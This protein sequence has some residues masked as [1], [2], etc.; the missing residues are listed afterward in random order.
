MEESIEEIGRIERFW[1]EHPMVAAAL[2]ALI[3]GS[4]GTTAELL[5][6][7]MVNS[8]PIDWGLTYGSLLSIPL[9]FI[10]FYVIFRCIGG[11]QNSWD[12]TVNKLFRTHPL[13]VSSLFA[14][15]MGFIAL[16]RDL[17]ALFVT[18]SSIRWGAVVFTVVV[19]IFSFVVCYTTTRAIAGLPTDKDSP[20]G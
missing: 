6:F 8:N 12:R 17:F 9:Y 3:I 5:V 4:L 19:A 18:N 20:D 13:L 10:V 16:L 2:T 14:L 11:V 1:M 7:P 15:M